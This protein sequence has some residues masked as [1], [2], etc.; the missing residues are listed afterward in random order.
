MTDL[1]DPIF[2]ILLIIIIIIIIIIIGHY[3]KALSAKLAQLWTKQLRNRK[4]TQNYV[5]A[6]HN[7]VKTEALNKLIL[8]STFSEAYKINK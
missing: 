8:F 6:S 2:R 4:N 7:F 5:Q 1:T 3:L